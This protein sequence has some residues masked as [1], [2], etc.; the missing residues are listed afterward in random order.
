MKLQRGR[1]GGHGLMASLSDGR[2]CPRLRIKKIRSLFLAAL[3]VSLCIY[4]ATGCD[5]TYNWLLVLATAGNTNTLVCA[6]SRG[7]LNVLPRT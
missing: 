7:G 2:K 1:A 3:C 4:D 6:R 5:G